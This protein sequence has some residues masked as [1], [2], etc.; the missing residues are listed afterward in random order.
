MR[1]FPR[2]LSCWRKRTSDLVEEL[3]THLSQTIQHPN[4][5]SRQNKIAV[6]VL[7]ALILPVAAAQTAYRDPQGRYDVQVPAGWQLAPGDSADQIVIHNGAAQA[8]ITVLQQ[9]ASS[10]MTA[11]EFVD[12]TGREIQGRCPTFQIRQS[13]QV[14][15]AGSPGVYS[16]FV[17]ND[18][19]SPT[20]AEASS[21]LTAS[22]VLIGFTAI[23]PLAQYY[24]SLPALDGIRDSLHVVGEQ[25]PA[26]VASVTESLAMTEIKK[27]CMAG[28][29]AQV[30]CARRI[31]I[32][33]GKE[34]AAAP[35]AA[36]AAGSQYRDPKGR[37]SFQVPKGWNAI[38]EGE[39]GV[40]GVQL[41][42]G[43]NWINILPA[44]PA[45]STSEVVLHQEQKVA[46]QS[47]SSRKP[48]F[49]PAGLLQQVVNGIEV[50][51]DHFGA[52]TPQG[53]AVETYIGGVGN[54]AGSGQGFLLM[55]AG[56]GAQQKDE[57]GPI[58]LAVAQSIVLPAH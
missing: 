36:P 50:N 26:V 24:E 2:I 49:G 20:V 19:K 7:A 23:A 29:F 53:E 45:A 55:I 14:A 15:L 21:A 52:V 9:N 41:R 25:S 34:L 39:N 13:G 27:A 17:C 54:L 30:E 35:V 28:V 5:L 37:F 57:A 10:A 31:S 8:L 44:D 56:F 22:G 33:M 46:A 51:Y 48:P 1:D 43:S 38:S 18:A 58:F 32:L 16:L 12:G 42:S 40:L 47:N 6:A 3:H 4:N 11:K